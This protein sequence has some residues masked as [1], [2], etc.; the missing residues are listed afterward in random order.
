MW[1]LATMLDTTLVVWDSYIGPMRCEFEQAY[2][3]ESR[4]VARMMGIPVDWVPRDR[5]ELQAYM[6]REIERGT[7]AVGSAGRKLARDLF[8]VQPPRGLRPI[9]SPA[10]AAAFAFALQSMPVEL[11][12]QFRFRARRRDALLFHAGSRTSRKI[13]RRLPLFLRVDPLTRRALLRAAP[14]PGDRA[15]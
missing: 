8:A 14:S 11:R 13:W 7:V 5:A 9:W 1:V 12:H 2:L 3:R 4:L 15:A 6:Q 10:R